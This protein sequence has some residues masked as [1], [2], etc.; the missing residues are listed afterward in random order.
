ME[1]LLV[2]IVVLCIALFFKIKFYFEE[3]HEQSPPIA[4][5]G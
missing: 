5:Q 4:Q 3:K 1:M 2:P